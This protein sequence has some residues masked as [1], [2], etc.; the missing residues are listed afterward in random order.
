MAVVAALADVVNW[1][2]RSGRRRAIAKRIRGR[3]EQHDPLLRKR[4]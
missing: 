4:I 2:D 3:K 1:G